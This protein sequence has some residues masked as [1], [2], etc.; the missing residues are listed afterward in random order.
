[1]TRPFPRRSG[2]IFLERSLQG[3]LTFFKDA[4]FSDELARRDGL[5]QRVDP[6]AKIACLIAVLLAM[7]FIHNPAALLAFYAVSVA[8]AALSRI[9]PLF[10]IKRTLFFIPLFA[11]F[12][13]LP[14]FF[15]YGPFSACLFVIRVTAC[16]SFA[17]LVSITTRHS[18]LLKALRG[19]GIPAVFVQILDMMYRYLFLFVCVFEEMHLALK[20]RLVRRFGP[21]QA[22]S[23]AVSRI[24]FLFK[25]SLRMSEEVYLAML[26]RGY[27]GEVKNDGE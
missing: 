4:L 21:R 2:N 17:V 10:F 9:G 5:L 19:L 13:A 6:R 11:F 23:W 12:I 26:A 16:V 20:A 25:R 24:G 18:A 3:A 14:A 27:T 7:S 22:R 1:M 8:L 15:M